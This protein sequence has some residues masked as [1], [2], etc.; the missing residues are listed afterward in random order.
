MPQTDTETTAVWGI[1][2]LFE[3]KLRAYRY[4][5]FCSGRHM[6]ETSPNLSCLTAENRFCCLKGQ[7][8]LKKFVK[9]AEM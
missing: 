7:G 5:A 6:I 1:P 8:P 9:N 4:K 2:I 3:N